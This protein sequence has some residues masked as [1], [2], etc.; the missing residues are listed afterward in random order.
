M[1]VLAVGWLVVWLDEYMVG[2]LVGRI[3]VCVGGWLN[4]LLDVCLDR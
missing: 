1:F 2:S 3:C 4:V